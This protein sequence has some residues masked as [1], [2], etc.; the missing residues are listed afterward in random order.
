MQ[1]HLNGF[2]PG[3]Y[4]VPDGARKPY[5]NPL[6]REKLYALSKLDRCPRPLC[7]NLLT[8][9]Y[10]ISLGIVADHEMETHTAYF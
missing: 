4:Q 5:P 8:M 6:I 9:L 3:N 7:C 10:Q 2:K 1:F